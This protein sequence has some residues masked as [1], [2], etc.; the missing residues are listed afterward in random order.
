MDHIQQS[1]SSIFSYS[2]FYTQ[3][4]DF[5]VSSTIFMNTPERAKVFYGLNLHEYVADSD[6]S[7]LQDS[8]IQM[9]E[10]LNIANEWLK[11]SNFLW[12][13]QMKCAKS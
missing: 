10:N 1:C 3:C 13:F 4:H 12:L 9:S 2:S 8:M 6:P 5:K 7:H 11:Y